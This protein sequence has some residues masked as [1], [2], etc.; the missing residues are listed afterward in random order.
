MKIKFT[1]RFKT[2]TITRLC[3][4]PSR[5]AIHKLLKAYNLITKPKQQWLRPI[6][7]ILSLG[8]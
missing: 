2:E 1:V 7:Y 8:L 6:V 4:V 5:V 3:S